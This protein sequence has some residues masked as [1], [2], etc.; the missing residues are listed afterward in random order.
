[1]SGTSNK[2]W[3]GDGRESWEVCGDVASRP[4]VSY[5]VRHGSAGE[6]RRWKGGTVRKER[7]DFGRQEKSFL[8]IGGDST[9]AADVERGGEGEGAGSK[10]E[11]RWREGGAEKGE[12]V[13]R[14]VTV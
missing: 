13:Q 1:M 9:T 8:I 12:D 4:P 7:M 11:W 2:G 3:P 10:G 14:T 5:E 6:K